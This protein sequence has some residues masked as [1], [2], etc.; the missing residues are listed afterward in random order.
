MHCA[1]L[2]P[3]YSVLA[4]PARAMYLSCP[5]SYSYCAC[6]IAQCVLCLYLLYSVL[7]WPARAM[8]LSCSCLYS[9]VLVP[10]HSVYCACIPCTVF[11]PGQ[12]GQCTY[13][14]RGCACT[15]VPCLYHCTIIWYRQ[16]GQCTYLIRLRALLDRATIL[17][18][19]LARCTCRATHTD[20]NSLSLGDASIARRFEIVRCTCTGCTRPV[21]VQLYA[22]LC[23]QLIAKW[24]GNPG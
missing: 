19:G 17:V 15:Y 12:H 7:A 9:T 22:C 1:C 18:F 5:C 4:W 2:Y 8:Y 20:M 3:L 21:Q 10:L 6:T 11:W 13:L 16:P 23:A 24:V 14:T